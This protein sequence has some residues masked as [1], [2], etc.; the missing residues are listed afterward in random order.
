[1]A[2]H[3]QLAAASLALVVSNG[4]AQRLAAADA[5]EKHYLYVTVPDGAGGA[6]K[7]PALYVYDIE[8]G[9]KLVKRI[10]VPEMKA[11]RGCCASA[12]A[13]KLFI[14]HGNTSLL[15]WDILTE[16]VVWNVTYPKEQGG[17]DRCCV[18]PDGKKVYV[19]EGWWSNTSRDLKVVDGETGKTLKTIPLGAG[20]GHNSIMGPTGERMYMGPINRGVLFVVDTK[21]DQI[22]KQFG[23]F[24]GKLGPDGKAAPGGPV[25]PGIK[26]FPG[27]RVSPYTINGSETLCFVNTSKVGFYVGDLVNQKVLH[28]MEVKEA[29]GFSHGVGMTPD[30]KEVWLIDPGG[31]KLHVFDA[32]VLP[33]KYVQPID[34]SASTHGWVTFDLL[35]RFAYPDTGDVIDA[36]TKKIVAEWKD[37]KGG[38]IRSS[39]FIEVHLKDGKVL[40]IG[41]QFGVGRQPKPP[42]AAALPAA[43]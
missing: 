24:G 41:D 3:L 39:K 32:T 26:K 10:A 4:L 11:T 42:V 38:R 2:K 16:K 22:I 25:D 15:C 34:I 9:H 18:T 17:A 27:G 8:D 13:A 30:E 37:D 36:K 7:G 5:A 35:G 21:T 20:G 33:P 12:A 14:S 6:G 31:K 43:P 1:M 19:P 23:G 28:W 40:R 29:K